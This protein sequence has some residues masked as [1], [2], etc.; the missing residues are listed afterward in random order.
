MKFSNILVSFNG[1]TPRSWIEE[2]WAEQAFKKD[3]GPTSCRYTEISGM[4]PRYYFEMPADKAMKFVAFCENLV[5][6]TC[7]QKEDYESFKPKRTYR[8]PLANNR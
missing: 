6:V 3:E 1:S 5:G 2:V 4:V 7:V 8:K